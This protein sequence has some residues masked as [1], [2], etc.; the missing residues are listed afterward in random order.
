V[1]KTLG[2]NYRYSSDML[3]EFMSLE[4]V[5]TRENRTETSSYQWNRKQEQKR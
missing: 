2:I 1:N 4:E 5:A 3:D